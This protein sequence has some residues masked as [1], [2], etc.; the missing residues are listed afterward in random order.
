M[1]HV[2]TDMA[3][4][5]LH[6]A[7]GVLPIPHPL[8]LLSCTS[9]KSIRLQPNL[10]FQQIQS[11]WHTGGILIR[12]LRSS[13]V[14]FD[15]DYNL[16]KCVSRSRPVS[17]SK[18][19]FSPAQ[20]EIFTPLVKAT[21][22]NCVQLSSGAAYRIKPWPTCTAWVCRCPT[23]KAMRRE[24]ATALLWK[25]TIVCSYLEMWQH[26]NNLE[27]ASPLPLHSLLTW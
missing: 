17:V 23:F 5:I 27:Q 1:P 4:P 2:C 6:L 12:L 7:Q 16:P 9:S 19:S 13:W 26:A 10:F 11:S 3:L 24:L 22:F 15:Q 25:P 14:S 21:T 20:K 18:G 8:K